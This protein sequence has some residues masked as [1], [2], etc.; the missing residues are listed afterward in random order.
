MMP[1]IEASQKHYIERHFEKNTAAAEMPFFFLSLS[2][3]SSTSFQPFTF[4][5]II[6]L[7]NVCVRIAVYSAFTEYWCVA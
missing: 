6:K 7:I 1:F 3:Y 4:H 2:Q 5:C